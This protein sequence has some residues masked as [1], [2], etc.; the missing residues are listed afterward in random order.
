MP[1]YMLAPQIKIVVGSTPKTFIC[2]KAVQ[3]RI[4]GFENGFDVGTVTFLDPKAVDRTTVAKNAPIAI[5]VKDAQE[6]SWSTMLVGVI[7]Y[8]TES[9]SKDK[10]NVII[11]KCDGAG[12]G[13]ADTVVGQEYGVQSSHPT[14]DTIKKILTDA[15]YG[16]VPKHVNKILG[17]TTDSG[18]AY[19][20]TKVDTIDGTINYLYFPFKPC[21]KALCDL[22]DLVQAIKGA[23][24]G[25]HWRV[26]TD[27]KL[28]VTTVGSHSADAAGEG[29]TT[30]AG[31][32]QVKATVQEGRDFHLYDFETMNAEANYILYYGNCIW[33]VNKD[34]LTEGNASA[35]TDWDAP[36]GETNTEIENDTTNYQ[37]GSGSIRCHMH[38]VVGAH[39]A[40]YPS[41]E[42]MAKDFSVL[43][44]RFAAPTINF[45]LRRDANYEP[46]NRVIV[47]FHTST[48]ANRWVDRYY[49]YLP[50][51]DEAGK[52]QYYSIPFGAFW[53]YSKMGGFATAAGYQ[54]GWVKV[55]NGS[56]ANVNTISFTFY[57][58]ANPC[59]V[60]IDGL[61]LEGWLLRG[62]YDST[63][64][65]SQKLKL[66]VVNDPF[67]KDDT[68]KAS[69]DSGTI[70][71]MAYAELLRRRTT[72]TIGTFQTKMIRA[73]LPG[74]LLHVHARPNAGGTF[75]IDQG[76][77]IIQVIQDL[78]AKGCA[79]SFTVTSDVINSRAR[80]AFD[81]INEV[82][83]SI[84]PEFQD[85]QSTGTKLRDI[86]ITQ[87]ILAKDYPS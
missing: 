29:W 28:L 23:N 77:R 66:Q 68:L 20:T 31:G 30:Y 6:T 62:A 54:G 83:K 4:N 18:F 33:P 37:V 72:P 84:R 8:V 44:G 35:W 9:L 81:S 27:D 1:T 7:R 40:A 2:R 71:R 56:W 87:A 45:W 79:S 43:G 65:A 5:Y 26:M 3:A 13:F 25:P 57:C 86:D 59:D 80:A 14:L 32:T 67:G 17:G 15:S 52:W 51:P 21:S 50:W 34:I 53:N 74:Q 85:R 11:A 58:A 19:T 22:I 41:T 63:L 42:D 36:G 82:N 55:G 76:M 60:Q 12:F 70:A 61:H 39:Y 16:I 69:D 49:C 64:I 38:A 73:A 48:G 46:S 47:T 24:A 78:A 10:G 75:Q